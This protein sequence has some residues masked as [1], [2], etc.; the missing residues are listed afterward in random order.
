MSKFKDFMKEYKTFLFLLIGCICLLAIFVGVATFS[1]SWPG[2]E[3]SSQILSALAGAVVAAMITLFLLIG[4][5]SGEEKKERNTK[6]FEEKLKIY[7]EFMQCLYEVVKD[8]EIREEDAIRLQFQTSYITMH[9]SSEHIK[10]IAKH[11]ESIVR[12]LKDDN[13]A[14]LMERIFAIVEQL[15]EELYLPNYSDEKNEHKSNIEEAVKSFSKIIN[16]VKVKQA[17]KNELNAINDE[18][19]NIAQN[20]KDFESA[21]Y[22][23]MK[24][25]LDHWNIE[26]GEYDEG[27]YVLMNMK[28][29]E[30]KVLVVLS[31]E[32]N[33]YKHF[34]QVHLGFDDSQEVYELMQEEFGGRKNKWSWWKYIDQ[35]W[36]QLANCQEIR[37]RKWDELLDYVEQ[38]LVELIKYVEEIVN[39][40]K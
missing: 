7:K 24:P 34:F 36:R 21:L 39:A 27:A 22:D 25:N 1:G 4:Q 12:D 35:R 40:R 17:E 18:S 30:E 29:Y 5:T 8:G 33:Y 20:I 11:V 14:R 16:A 15:K 38:E 32:E 28:G 10:E 2:S 13:N 6:V 31:Y 19:I 3:A 26:L 37:T 9:T 23:K